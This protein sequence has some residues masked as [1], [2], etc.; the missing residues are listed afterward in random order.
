MS[1]VTAVLNNSAGATTAEGVHDH[2]AAH[3]RAF[4]L[5]T[6]ME[7]V[8]FSRW[9]T[10]ARVVIGSATFFDAFDA[11]S[12][13]FILPVL[14]GLWKI[15]PTQIGLLIGS[16]YIGQ[17]IGAL[18]FGW[19]AERFGRIRSAAWAVGIMSVMGLACAFVGNYNGLLL[20]R[21]IQGIGLGG[22]VPVAASYINELSRAHG[23]GKFF[24]LYELIFPIGLM[25]ASQLGVL[26]VPNYGWQAMFY[27]GAIPGLIILFFILHLPESPRWL[28]SK[29]RLD[30]AEKIVQEIEASTD[31]RQE[32]PKSTA[33]QTATA[34]G[35]MKKKG[36]LKEILSSTYWSRTLI[37]W[38]LW[39]A[40]YFVANG[41]NN[42][43][44][45]L[46]KTVY[47]LPLQEALRYASLTNLVQVVI[48]IA[49]ALLIDKVGRKAWTTGAFLIPAGLFA[50]LW[51]LGA[52]SFFTVMIMMTCSYAVLST[53]NTLLYLY[54]PEIYPTRMRAVATGLATAW[55]R[56][57][58]A[59]GPMVVGGLVGSGGMVMVFAVFSGVCVLGALASRGMIETRGR[60]LEE[61]AP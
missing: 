12:L 37:V 15:S 46:Y 18:A 26:I 55:L 43:L 3:H 2:D 60:K 30:E 6:R 54:T 57:A 44:P 17:F 10:K 19:L 22:E 45:T 48:T 29:G 7:S 50:T 39:A 31:K 34:I 53:I 42:W 49:C 32:P 58:S 56:L 51:F 61:I 8:P 14:I 27:A 25:A 21:F 4:S 52:N 16:S 23:R 38:C 28:I 20:C 41:L 47:H 11:L 5:I 9:H 35:N 33:A 1:G 59:F 24:M 13:A 36:S 40:S